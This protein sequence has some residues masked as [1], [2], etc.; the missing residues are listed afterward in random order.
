MELSLIRH[1]FLFA[2]GSLCIFISGLRSAV[3]LQPIEPAGPILHQV[4]CLLRREDFL[5]HNRVK[6]NF[7][8]SRD[9]NFDHRMEPST[10]SSEASRD[11]HSVANSNASI[12]PFTRQRFDVSYRILCFELETDGSLR[13]SA[14]PYSPLLLSGSYP[15]HVPHMCDSLLR[16]RDTAYSRGYFGGTPSM[17][18]VSE[19]YI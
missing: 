3:P 10:P 1:F 8:V 17:R 18:P 4:M 19:A 12:V 11:S 14:W 16:E 15:S 13:W 5:N 9:C 7:R 6:N 2:P